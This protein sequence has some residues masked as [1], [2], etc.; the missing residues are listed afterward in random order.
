MELPDI[1]TNSLLLFQS[2]CVIVLAAYMVTRSRYF[3]AVIEG[4]ATWKNKAVL[5]VFFG[6]LSIYGSIMGVGVSGAILNIRDLG[7]I[8]GGI[9]C[10][11]IVGLGAGIIGAIFR[12]NEGGFTAVPCSI[13]VLLAG[14]VGGLIYLRMGKFPGI[15]IS[16]AF[17][18]SLEVF[19]MLLTLA[20]ARPYSQALMVVEEVM[21]PMIL[22][23]ALGVLL[24]TF[25][26]SN[27]LM[28]IETK[29]ERDK[30][31]AEL[32]R[33][34]AE[35]A[36]AADIQKSFLPHHLPS[37]PGFDLAAISIPAL[38]VGGDFYDFISDSNGNL[39]IA[40]ADVAGK[41][42][43]A[44]LFMA[45]SKT[46][47]RSDALT[48]D[49]VADALKDSNDIIA[50]ESSSGM[51]VTLFLGIL[52][53]RTGCLAYSNAGHHPPLIL[54]AKD[55]KFD[56]LGVTGIALGIM[57]GSVYSRGQTTLGPGDIMVMYTDGIVEAINPQGEYFGSE[58]LKS[59]IAKSSDQSPNAMLKE[60]VDK[61]FSFS[62]DQPQFD[63]ITALVV[64]AK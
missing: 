62:G 11:P 52:N 58:R 33:K 5:T 49:D 14:L 1:L 46:I 17:A 26:V 55:K 41:G 13:A 43:P 53:Q 16:M 35:L 15:A 25:I 10:G 32:E 45:L 36:L 51:F 59:I 27:F 47:V 56:I 31:R 3:A 28:E 9:T 61:V 21:G 60:I 8:V 24:F 20:L 44:A 6:L 4:N 54:R 42:I 30:Y 40:I 7:P 29:S 22:G 38:E 2:M 57:E 48:H 39:G 37:I 50:S 64:K 63:D 12:L 23:N 18:V 34:K 19:H